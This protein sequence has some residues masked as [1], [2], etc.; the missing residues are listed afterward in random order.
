MSSQPSI[1]LKPHSSRNVVPMSNSAPAGSTSQT[2]EPL[3]SIDEVAR[4]LAVSPATIR[5]WIHRKR[6]PYVKMGRRVGFHPDSIRNFIA[7]NTR[8]AVA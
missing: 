6:L 2:L 4:I 5:T 3:L 8:A 1:D 7:K